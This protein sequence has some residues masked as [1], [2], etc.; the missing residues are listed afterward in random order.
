MNNRYIYKGKRKDNGGWI[1]G[2]LIIDQYGKYYIHPNVNAFSV[3]EYNL[4]KCIQ[5]IEVIP[6][7]VGQCTG[8]KDKNGKLIFEGGVLKGFNYPFLSDG[9]FNYYAVVIWFENSPAFGISTVKNPQSK[10]RGIS[11][12]NT[13]FIYDWNSNDWEVIGNIHDNP[14]LLEVEK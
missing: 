13:D 5:M 7:T 4:A 3:N 11:D 1:Y 14:E 2:D 10:V 6:E 12:G 9:E 8:L